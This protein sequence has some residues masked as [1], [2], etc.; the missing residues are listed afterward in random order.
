MHYVRYHYSRRTVHR[1]T[2][3]TRATYR[4]S[5][6]RNTLR[7]THCSFLLCLSSFINL[8]FAALFA[9]R[10]APPFS[11]LLLLP[12]FP[13]PPLPF[14]FSP[15]LLRVSPRRSF[16]VDAQS[17]FVYAPLKIASLLLAQRELALL[18]RPPRISCSCPRFLSAFPSCC[19]PC[20]DGHPLL[21]RQPN[22]LLTTI[23][24][25]CMI[26]PPLHAR[27]Y[28]TFSIAVISAV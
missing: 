19:R 7:S 16:P 6:W 10:A 15:L 3:I 4:P 21:R 18:A 13:A 28:C 26:P 25:Y 24:A 8:S 11:F 22:P 23:S 2:L 17:P 12:S 14:S 1:A 9:V 5:Y 20:S 27:P